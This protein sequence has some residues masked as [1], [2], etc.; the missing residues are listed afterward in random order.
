MGNLV[1]YFDDSGTHVGSPIVVM[2]GFT[3]TSAQW[4][5]FETAWSDRLA[6]PL[7]GRPPLRRFHMAPCNA[8]RDDFVDWSREQCAAISD[9]FAQIIVDAGVVGYG[10][11]ISQSDWDELISGPLRDFYGD[12]EKACVTFCILNTLERAAAFDSLAPVEFVFDNRPAR[13]DANSRIFNVFRRNFINEDEWVEPV[14]ISFESSDKSLPLQAADIL[15]WELHRYGKAWLDR[16]EVP[17]PLSGNLR[18][19]TEGRKISV[20]IAMRDAISRIAA[21]TPTGMSYEDMA[22]FINGPENTAE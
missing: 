19:L 9:A 18:K 6:M 4:K 10:I 1:A 14:S 22:N 8:Q 13:T 7:P 11:A 5:K 15:A 12:A 21:E 2:A 17:L 3:G 20:Q 16:G